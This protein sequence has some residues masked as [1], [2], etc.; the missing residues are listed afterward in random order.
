MAMSH[1]KQK[2]I[3]GI[4]KAMVEKNKLKQDTVTKDEVYQKAVKEN[5]RLALEICRALLKDESRIEGIENLIKLNKL[6][7]EGKSCLI[8]SEH[9]SNLDVPNLYTLFYDKYPEYMYIFENV[10]FIAG[11]KLNEETPA[12]KIFA[13]M[14][15]RLIIV[16][17]TTKVQTKEEQK[18]M[19]AINRASQ[20]WIRENKTKGHIFLLYP[21]GTR[22]RDWLPE[23]KKGIREAYNYLKN[24]DYFCPASI[25]GNTMP[26]VKDS[27]N[28]LEDPCQEDNVIYSFGEVV[29]TE[30]FIK[31]NLATIQAQEEVDQKQTIVDKLMEIIYSIPQKKWK[32]DM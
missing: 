11:K 14:F 24:F 4:V 16:P 32:P 29:K 19:F 18:Q 10:T 1:K 17:K 25:Q 13:E 6:A 27:P 22:T 15:N 9:K 28:M 23:T 21:T 7:E 8:A 30:D 12:V 20:K 2:E 31:E 3:F 5:R 26:A